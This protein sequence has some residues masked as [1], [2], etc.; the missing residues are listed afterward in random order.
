V[1]EIFAT[2]HECFGGSAGLRIFY[3]LG[4]CACAAKRAA[5][6]RERA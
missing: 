5:L 4:S 6:S 2:V 1:G 3:V